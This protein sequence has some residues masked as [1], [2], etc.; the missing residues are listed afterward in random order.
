MEPRK[1]GPI[2]NVD[3]RNIAANTTC[4][5]LWW[6]RTLHQADVRRGA[7]YDIPP[8]EFFRDRD[9]CALDL[10]SAAVPSAVARHLPGRWCAIGAR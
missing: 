9:G 8:K 1:A 5:S 3:T 7:G 2:T 10:K 6:L 4:G